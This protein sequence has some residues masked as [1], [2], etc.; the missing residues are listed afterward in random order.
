MRRLSLIHVLLFVLLVPSS[1][2]LIQSITYGN[3]LD[4]LSSSGLILFLI[5]SQST[6]SWLRSML[7]EPV[8]IRQ[9][10]AVGL[11]I[12]ADIIRVANN[13]LPIWLE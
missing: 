11:M 4:A 2:N 6:V 9:W 8:P 13:V 7:K 3:W 1:I 12:T 5:P 10:L